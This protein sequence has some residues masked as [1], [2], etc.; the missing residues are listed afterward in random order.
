[1]PLAAALLFT[2]CETA[3]YNYDLEIDS[4]AA[5]GQRWGPTYEIKP[6]PGSP[7]DTDPSFGGVANIIGQELQAKTLYP[8][9][10]GEQADLVVLVDYGMSPPTIEYRTVQ[11]PAPVG[12]MGIDPITGVP[13][14]NTGFGTGGTG[15]S[16]ITYVEEVRAFTVIEKYMTLSAV[17]GK[18]NPETGS[19]RELANVTVKSADDR[20]ELDPY[21]PVLAMATGR[22]LGAPTSGSEEVTI[23]ADR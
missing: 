5:V 11:V 14:R 23:K 16:Q 1:M 12:T 18:V 22:Q 10:P 15:V 9:P 2:G 19:R 21:L 7:A 20:E 13:I 17:E 3:T 4:V 6:V 8:A